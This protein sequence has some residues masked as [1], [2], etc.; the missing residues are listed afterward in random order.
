MTIL[1]TLPKLTGK[2]V[3]DLMDAVTTK[4]ELA[5]VVQA[6][7]AFAEWSSDTN[8]VMALDFNP[9]NT[10]RALEAALTWETAKGLVLIFCHKP[11]EAL[12]LVYA[13]GLYPEQRDGILQWIKPYE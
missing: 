7:D 9:A 12:A 4:Q 6:A 2:P 8:K 1:T 11:D 3:R 5:L 10:E 13:L